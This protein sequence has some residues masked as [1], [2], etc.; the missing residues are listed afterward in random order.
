M[1]DSTPAPTPSPSPSPELP[2]GAA[3]SSPS[4][5]KSVVSYLKDTKEV[6]AAIGAIGVAIAFA[7]NYFATSRALNC[8]KAESR[9]SNELVQTVL[10]INVLTASWES[11][12]LMLRQLDSKRQVPQIQPGSAELDAILKDIVRTQAQTDQIT[13][14]LKAARERKIALERATEPCE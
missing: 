10:Q 14:E 1:P 3:P 2:H 11:T 4:R 13:A 7:L 5:W 12:S 8:F 6:L 9:K